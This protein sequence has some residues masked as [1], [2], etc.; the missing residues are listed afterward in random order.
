M[1]DSLASRIEA[2]Q[3]R[4]ALACQRAGRKAEEV[5]LI[6][7][8]KTLPVDV[9][10]EAY[11]LGLRQFGE[12]RLQEALPKIEA[13]PSDIT[14]H[15]IG[16]FQSNKARKAAQSFQ[17]IHTLSTPEHVRQVEKCEV[18]ID[19]CVQVNLTNEVQKSG[20]SP[21][22]LDE[23]LRLGLQCRHVQ[24]RGLMTMGRLE[25]A[26]DENRA[27]FR[28]LRKMTEERGLPWTSMGMSGDFEVAIMEGATHI[29]IGSAIF[30]E[31]T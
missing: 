4:I 23:V 28:R 31:R 20:T 17:C 3:E 16:A 25:A 7:V 2:V 8:T 6:A 13:L 15:F 14:W 29:R 27:V 10:A 1:A 21:E 30:G 22:G 26:E 12:N 5:C 19:C 18:R 11:S 24:V 9:L